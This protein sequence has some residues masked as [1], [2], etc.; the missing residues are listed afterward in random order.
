MKIITAPVPR[1]INS[2]HVLVDDDHDADADVD[3]DD[4]EERKKKKIMVIMMKIII[5]K[6]SDF[7]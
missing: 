6:C 1:T 5:K 4:D 7:K 3:D 2:I